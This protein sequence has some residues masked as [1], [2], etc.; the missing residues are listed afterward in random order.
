[1][2]VRIVIVGSSIAA[3][4]TVSELRR[5]GWRD[6]IVLVGPEADAPYDRPPLSKQVLSGVWEPSRA[7]LE[8]P[9]A[10]G[11]Q[12][13]PAR[14]IGLDP[15]TRTVD[16][17]DGSTVVYDRLV[18]ATGAEPRRLHGP[19]MAGG[20]VL[21]SMGDCLALRTA[22]VGASS[23]VVIGGG[24]IGAEV[25]STARIL[26]LD[27][28]ILEAFSV[29]MGRALGPA[30]GQR[31][32]ER[33]RANGVRVWTGAAVESLQEVD[34]ISRIGL[35]DGRSLC[36]DVAVVGIGVQ[37]NTEWLKESGLP[38]D[39]GV[40]CDATCQVEGS[41]YSIFAVGD[42]AR[43]W[44][45]RRQR[46]VRIE[47][48]TNAVDQ[49]VTVAHNIVHSDAPRSHR[50]LPYFWS[51]QLGGKL[52]LVGEAGELPVEMW[53]LGSSGNR[54]AALYRNGATLA[55]AVTMSSP[56]VLAALRPLVASAAP[57][58]DA[59]ALLKSHS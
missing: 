47:H 1:M 3:V 48:W 52:Q 40:V 15:A 5:Q 41:E 8:D 49:A 13:I 31:L 44:D 22:M 54:F 53:T 2:T 26:G 38:L 55:G 35:G 16:L 29:P 11:A 34:G 51:D 18:I 7:R 39:D 10:N 32:V 20:H 9:E 56:R 42:V 25:A 14:A 23:L 17:E 28:T 19:Q 36:A 57:F 30:V 58:A 43:W 24:F 6:D 37:P 4:R 59:A 27:V 33:H 45:E 46:H 12:R 50:A 21:R